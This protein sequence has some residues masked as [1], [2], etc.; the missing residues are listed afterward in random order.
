MLF[1]ASIMGRRDH[2][3]QHTVTYKRCRSREA[4]KNWF[5]RVAEKLYPTEAGWFVSITVKKVADA[6]T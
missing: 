1:I 6:D 5:D 2:Q 3:Y 4:A